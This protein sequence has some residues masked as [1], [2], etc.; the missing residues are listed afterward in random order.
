MEGAEAER[1][2]VAEARGEAEKEAAVRAERQTLAEGRAAEQAAALGLLQPLKALTLELDTLHQ[3]TAAAVAYCSAQGAATFADLVGR[4]SRLIAH[5]QAVL[6]CSRGPE[7]WP[8]GSLRGGVTVPQVRRVLAA[9][10][11]VRG[12]V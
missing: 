12:Q 10:P 5:P 2:K 4:A 11:S 7:L 3:V 8:C 9:I 6:E 1:K